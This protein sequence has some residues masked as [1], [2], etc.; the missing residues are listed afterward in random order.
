MEHRNLRVLTVFGIG[1][2][3]IKL[4]PVQVNL[5]KNGDVRSLVVSTS[6]QQKVYRFLFKAFRETLAPYPIKKR[7]KLRPVGGGTN[8]WVRKEALHPFDR[9]RG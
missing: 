2:E 9:W 6:H 8:D 5:E 4:Y 7:Y 3:D 1:P